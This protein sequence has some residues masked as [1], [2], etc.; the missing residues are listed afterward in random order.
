MYCAGS[1]IWVN[2]LR[3][4]GPRLE[5]SAAKLRGRKF[6]CFYPATSVTQVLIFPVVYNSQLSRQPTNII[7]NRPSEC[8]VKMR[9]Q[10]LNAQA[11]YL[12]TER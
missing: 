9:V 10:C 11:V 5:Q 3:S 1:V 8:F 12:N 4:E 6:K 7:A 2:N